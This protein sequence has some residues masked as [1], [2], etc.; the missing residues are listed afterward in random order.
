MYIN[1][2]QEDVLNCRPV[3][4]ISGAGYAYQE[5]RGAFQEW[6]QVN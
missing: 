5:S 3:M 4:V 6:P 1:F 2:D